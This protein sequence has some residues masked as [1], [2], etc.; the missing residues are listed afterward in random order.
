MSTVV[1]SSWY[2]PSTGHTYLKVYTNKSSIHPVGYLN[3][4]DHMVVD[5]IEITSYYIMHFTS[6]LDYK[7]IDKPGVPFKDKL[8]NKAIE[9]LTALKR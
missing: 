4:F 6:K 5:N 2:N 9:T 1:L 3:Q 7:T 8:I